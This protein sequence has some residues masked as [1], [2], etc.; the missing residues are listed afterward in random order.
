M[1]TATLDECSV[2]HKE[3]KSARLTIRT[4]STTK[5]VIDRAAK[6]QGV[7]K[8]AFVVNAAYDRAREVI[9]DHEQTVMSEKGYEQFQAMLDRPA[10]P[11][12][13]LVEAMKKYGRQFNGT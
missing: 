12:P 5:D 10:E 8:S 11:I 1:A 7:D 13:A 6:L 9:S 2:A 4:T 3:I